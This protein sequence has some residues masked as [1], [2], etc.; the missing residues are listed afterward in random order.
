MEERSHTSIFEE[1]AIVERVAR[2]VSSVR[3]IR[4]DYTRLAA[5]L[6]Q[7]I[8][9]DV[10]GIVLLRHDRQAVRVVV[11]RREVG[12]GWQ[13]L[14][15]QLPKEESMLARVLQEPEMVVNEY[16]DGLDGPPSVSGDAL[17]GFHQ[18]HSTLIVPLRVEES[19]LGTLELG[20]T[21]EHI[22]ADVTLQRLVGAVA[23]VVASAIESAQLGGSAE[24]QNRQRQVL[25]DVSSALTSK[26]D[27]STILNQI[28][29]GIAESLNVSSLIVMQERREGRLRMEAHAGLDQETLKRVFAQ[30]IPISDQCI[31]G[32]SLQ[33]RRPLFSQDIAH[34]PRFPLSNDL[35]AQFD[36]HSVFCYP[37]VTGTTVYGA[38]LLCATE[39]GGFTPLKIDILS[40]FASQATV[41]IHNGILLTSAHQRS[42]FQVAIE[43][44]EHAHHDSASDP[45]T[46]GVEQGEGEQAEY[47]Q[48]ARMREETQ[49]TFGVSFASLMRFIGDHLLTQSEQGL[50]A[51]LSAEQ[52]EPYFTALEGMFNE[53]EQDEPPLGQ[54]F[55][56]GN[57]MQNDEHKEPLADTLSLLTQTAEAALARTGMLSELSRL[58]LQ[59]QQ[60]ADGVKDAWFVI[61]FSG[62]C[63]YLNPAAETLCDMRLEQIS[64]TYGLQ[65]LKQVN[66][67]ITI[68]Y[69]FAKLLPRV[70]N[71]E[72]VRLYLH[73]FMLGNVYQQELRCVLAAEPL[74]APVL[75]QGMLNGRRSLLEHVPSDHYYQFARY[76]L[77]NQQGQISANALQVRDVTEQVRDE[78]NRSALLSAVSHDLRTPLTTIK[79]AVT[80]LLQADVEWEEH[81]RHAM[82]EDIDV[83]ADHLTVLVNALVELSRIEMGA[84]VLEKEWCDVA[85]VAYGALV[86]VGRVLAGRAVSTQFQAHLPLIYVDHVQLERV[87]YNLLENVVRSS[88]QQVEISVQVGVE[89]ESQKLLCVRVLDYGYEVPEQERERIFQSFY[90]P[91]SD[92]NGLGLAICKGIIEAHQGH[93]SV[94]GLPGGGSCFIFTIPIYPQAAPEKLA[95]AGGWGAQPLLSRSVKETL[96]ARETRGEDEL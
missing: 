80:G 48:F 45:H 90:S 26:M 53:N 85:E 67:H 74:Y 11:C 37:L 33:Q 57:A 47:K 17:S 1:S 39:P 93:I 76:P 12:S 89:G 88:P 91:G 52:D 18:L 81:D 16:P 62:N 66:E 21:V 51:I 77:Y 10:F 78:K 69:A 32:Q 95:L 8:S 42:R 68:E 96:Q 46:Y 58:L 82:L 60:S 87:F 22:Y 94:E 72:E 92:S 36:I 7:A 63:V 40:L 25:K 31:I 13:T 30:S 56:Q 79:A 83:E 4:P 27:L 59:V 75:Q 50:Q 70:R 49:R 15:H 71:V 35:F 29:K 86:K 65:I 24:I 9:F 73:E 38:L 44:L 34:D 23:Q 3:G 84:L 43:R 64:A 5:E 14:Q 55:L 2:I 19:V 54:T 61:D 41:A 6:E 20:S 28:V